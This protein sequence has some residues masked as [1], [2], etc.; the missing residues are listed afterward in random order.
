MEVMD[1]RNAKKP[2]VIGPNLLSFY[3][4]FQQSLNFSL[5]RCYCLLV[6][7]NSLGCMS[8]GTIFGK[9]AAPN[10][11][12]VVVCSV[13]C[14]CLALPPSRNS[15]PTSSLSRENSV[16]SP[17]RHAI[18]ILLNEHYRSMYMMKCG[19]IHLNV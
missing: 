17:K 4:R 7:K 2:N 14:C 12:Y 9:R 15:F 18:H 5:D 8:L 3:C 16:I 13:T 10:I 1:K 11:F 6:H 19:Q